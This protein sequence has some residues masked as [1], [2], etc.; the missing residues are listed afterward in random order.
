M[1]EGR[2]VIHSASA[3]PR[4][5]FLNLDKHSRVFALFAQLHPNCSNGGAPIES[6]STNNEKDTGSFRARRLFGSIRGPAEEYYHFRS[7]LLVFLCLWFL[8]RPISL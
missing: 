2:V 3:P 4:I 7:S 5:Y 8:L 1:K 6:N